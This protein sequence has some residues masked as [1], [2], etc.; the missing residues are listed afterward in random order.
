VT[1]PPSARDRYLAAYARLR[2]REGR[3]RG[4]EAE[5]LALPHLA[6]GPLAAQWGVRA[7][8][9]ERFVRAVLRPLARRAGRPLRILDLGAGNGW[10]CYRAALLGH[11]G[12]AVDVRLDDVDGLPAGAPYARHLPRMFGRVAA[13]FERLPLAAK[14]FDVAVFD[15][16]LHYAANLGAV[17]REAARVVAG[18]GRIA[19][20]DSPFYARAEDGEAMI[21]EKT[22]TTRERFPDLAE[23]L[24]GLPSIEYLT[25]ERLEAAARLLGLEFVRR[26]VLYPAWYEWR[27][28]SARLGRKRAPSR[29][30][31]WDSAVP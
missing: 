24:L 8:T 14:S 2:E 1:T 19:I 28:I 27:A 15:A 5:L 18:G 21:A 29:F 7:R 4:G 9:H 30:D 31:L 25:H 12:L 23:D 3:G 22:R 10:L 13:S 17:L 6:K 11:S 16:S 26:R 20:L